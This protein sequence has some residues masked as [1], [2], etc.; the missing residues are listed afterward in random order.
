MTLPPPNSAMGLSIP[1]AS[2]P[3]VTSLSGVIVQ[4]A[5]MALDA[6]TCGRNVPENTGPVS[7]P[8]VF[9]VT[10]YRPS[11]SGSPVPPP[12]YELH[13]VEYDRGWK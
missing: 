13:E 8:S 9:S 3:N 5:V 11:E 2:A 4:T 12:S 1:T 7:V 10:A 6:V